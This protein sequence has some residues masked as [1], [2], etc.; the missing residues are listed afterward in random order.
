MLTK[1]LNYKNFSESK[2][3][4]PNLK[5][6]EVNGF[7]Y[8]IGRD[9]A[10]N[11]YLTFQLADDDDI[12]FHAK[13]Y[14]GSHM[15]V[16]IKNKLPDEKDLIEF[17]KISKRYSKAKNDKDVEI[18]YAKKKFIDKKPDYKPGKVDVDDINSNT[19]KI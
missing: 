11:D 13:G 14:P 3:K 15:I 2:K 10:S 9:S 7:I 19:I 1:I 4:F 8:Y 12:W 18:V 6:G 17:A 16:K 5:K